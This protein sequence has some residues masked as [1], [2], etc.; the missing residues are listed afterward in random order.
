MRRLLFVPILLIALAVW[1]QPVVTNT[2]H[3]TAN[4]LA[5]ATFTGDLKCGDKAYYRYTTAVNSTTINVRCEAGVRFCL[6]DNDSDGLATSRAQIR[7]CNTEQRELCGNNTSQIVL[8]L[9]LD[10]DYTTNTACVWVGQGLY[11]AD[12]TVA[13][14]ATGIIEAVGGG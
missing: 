3:K 13:P 7:R 12:V 11:Y 2:W 1:A 5:T 6:S 9:T 14:A 8:N 4:P 10:G